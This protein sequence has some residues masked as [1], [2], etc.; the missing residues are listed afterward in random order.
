MLDREVCSLASSEQT[1]TPANSN[2]NEQKKVHIPQR[3]NMI[4]YYKHTHI[5]VRG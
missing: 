2:A 1:P 4:H 3:E 5:Y